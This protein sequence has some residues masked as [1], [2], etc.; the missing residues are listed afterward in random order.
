M[1]LA[2][3]EVY[4]AILKAASKYAWQIM[5]ARFTFERSISICNSKNAHLKQIHKRF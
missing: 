3:C 5:L 2:S 1:F 4:Y